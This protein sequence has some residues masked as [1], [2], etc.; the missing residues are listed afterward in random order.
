MTWK[1]TGDELQL[2]GVKL[3]NYYAGAWLMVFK[4][5]YGDAK[6]FRAFQRKSYNIRSA[7]LAPERGN[8][9]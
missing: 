1:E 2:P 5:C 8:F 4:Y 3:A 6:L 7:C 9:L